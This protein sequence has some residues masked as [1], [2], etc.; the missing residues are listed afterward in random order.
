MANPA[1]KRLPEAWMDEFYRHVLEDALAQGTAAYWQRRARTFEEARPRLADF[2]G[3]T[4][5]A[6]LQAADA[7]LRQVAHAC[8]NRS[9]LAAIDGEY[10]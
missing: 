3:L 9:R 7:R 5:P 6:D 8:R 4:S 2:P 1:T 10:R